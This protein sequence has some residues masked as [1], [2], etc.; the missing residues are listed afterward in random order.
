MLKHLPRSGM[1]LLL[2][3]FSL[4]WSLDC[5]PSIWKTSSDILIHRMGKPFDSPAFLSA[6]LFLALLVGLNLSFLI[7]MLAWC[8]SITNVVSFESIKVF[9]KDSFLALHFSLFI[10]DLPASLPSSILCSLCADNLAIWSSSP[11]ALEAMQGA[12]IRLER[13]SEYWCFPLNLRKCEASS[14]NPNQ[15]NLQPNLL[16]LNSC[17]HFN[18]TPTF[19]GVIFHHAFFFSK[20]VSSLKAKFFP[21]LEALCCICFLMGPL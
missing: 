16:L 8:I 9:C 3:I 7:G 18:P 6:Y 14:V 5:F 10:N 17:F 4:L 19:L 2:Y 21:C 11:T 13:W 15:V 20:H 1:D 12:L